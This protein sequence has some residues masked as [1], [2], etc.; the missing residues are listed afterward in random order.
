V[1]LGLNPL[2]REWLPDPTPLIARAQ[3]AGVVGMWTELLHFQYRQV[4]A[5][6]DREKASIG[7]D[8][9]TR[10]SKRRAEQ[11]DT[12]H[13]SQAR[14]TAL[15]RGMEVY[16][17]GQGCRSDFFTHYHRVYQDKTF[18]VMQDWVNWC[19]DREAQ[20]QLIPFEVFAT[21]MCDHLPS[22][23]HPIDSYLGAVMHNLWWTHDVPPQMSYRQLL[24]VIWRQPKIKYSPVKL[25]CFAYA[26]QWDDGA[27]D[28]KPGWVVYVDQNDHPYLCFDPAGF[29]DYYTHVDLVGDALPD[30]TD[31]MPASV[32]EALGMT[33][34][35][36]IPG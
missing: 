6:T 30:N 14:H 33:A 9:L 26:A 18:R 17:I 2:V 20:S 4:R 15:D 25:S 10:A 3:D 11:A 31:T 28:G 36:E 5:M 23:V 27:E 32:F 8:I 19:F 35:Q 29:A 16:S 34:M 21:F 7:D 22:G 13:L 1:M 24:S 12:D